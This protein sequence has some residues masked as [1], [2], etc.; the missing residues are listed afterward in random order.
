MRF[1]YWLITVLGQM[2]REPWILGIGSSRHNGAVCLLR[3]NR[4]AAAVQEERLTRMKRARHPAGLASLAVQYCLDTAGITANDL[5]AIGVCRLSH[6][7]SNEDVRQSP[8]LRTIAGR[9]PVTNISHHLGHA[10]AVFATSGFESATVVIA[11]GRGSPACQLDATEAAAIHAQQR[12]RLDLDDPRVCE[13]LTF[14]HAQGAKLTAIEKHIGRA[15]EQ[16]PGRMR[17]L[18]SLGA[19]FH[20]A[21]SQVFGE[22]LDGAGKLMGLAPFGVPNIP[23]SDFFSIEGDEFI[24]SEAVCDRFV[25]DD[26][27]PARSKEYADL[28]ASTQCALEEAILYVA[29]RARIISSETRLCYAGGVALNSVANERLIRESGFDD[30]FI[31]P[32]A[33]DSG[34]AIGAAYAALWQLTEFE[35]GTRQNSDSMGRRYSPCE[36]DVAIASNPRAKR[37]DCGGVIAQAADLL[38]NGKIVGWF[39]GGSE[40]GPRALGQRSILADPRRGDIKDTL[41]RRVKFRE[42]FRPYA[43][44]VLKSRAHEWFDTDPSSLDSPFMLRVMNV[45][46]GCRDLVPGIVHADGTARV[47]TVTRESNPPLHDLLEAYE[48]ETG[49]P[50]LLNTSFNIA[51]EPIVETPEEALYCFAFSGLDGCVLGERIV[52]AD[53]DAGGPLDW[54]PAVSAAVARLGDWQSDASN[55]KTMGRPILASACGASVPSDERQ[56]L[57]A[58][59][60]CGVVVV[61]GRWGRTIHLLSPS[62]SALL[63]MVDG[64]HTG[65]ELLANFQ[66]SKIMCSELEIARFIGA[67]AALGIVTLS[68]SPRASAG[69]K[70][71]AHCGELEPWQ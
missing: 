12:G 15:S 53:P 46:E 33:E 21:G 63:R 65:W 18:F 24:Y 19:L 62:A 59:G 5:S 8:Q 34:T 58:Q 6:S 68:R 54:L 37:I 4:V 29:K 57:E 26:R 27:W 43:P 47:Q 28:A 9:V 36:I 49:V 67:L 17:S 7:P 20:C 16:R 1:P 69:D 39:Q 60:Q 22:P 41:N 66:R 51:G 40:L 32:A 2:R 42:S 23:I 44:A 45:K 48:R 31:M 30:V 56:R 70:R 52:V 61:D 35:R 10:V 13:T 25:H 3:G 11:D 38:A 14:Y 71:L 50:I 64:R 55:I